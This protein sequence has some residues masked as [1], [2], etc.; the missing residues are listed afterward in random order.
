MSIIT[1][2]LVYAIYG[3]NAEQMKMVG[4]IWERGKKMPDIIIHDIT[5]DE[6]AEYDNDSI[7]YLIGTGRVDEIDAQLTVDAVEVVRCKNCKWFHSYKTAIWCE[8]EEGL[9]HPKY[10]SFC[11]Y[12]ERGEDETD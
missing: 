4:V 5:M 6:F 2:T 7:G 11:S 12:G 9:N 1:K 8:K 3:A 10:D